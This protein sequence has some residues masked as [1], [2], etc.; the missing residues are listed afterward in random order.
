MIINYNLKAVNFMK[1]PNLLVDRHSTLN[2]KTQVGDL[3]HTLMGSIASLEVDVGRPV[4]GEVLRVSAA[5]TCRR[6]RWVSG[7]GSHEALKEL[8]PMT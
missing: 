4:V 1:K 3:R 8:P 5:G 6:L 2:S 7:A